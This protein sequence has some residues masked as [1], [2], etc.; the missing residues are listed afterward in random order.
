MYQLGTFQKELKE[1]AVLAQFSRIRGRTNEGA[2]PVKYPKLL[3]E[4]DA[5][6]NT[7][8]EA[9]LEDFVREATRKAKWK[10]RGR[11]M[12]MGKNGGALKIDS[13]TSY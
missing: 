4:D 10:S 8:Q 13:V 5:R 6:D 12:Q 1:A 11:G 7:L 3:M 2:G 9:Q